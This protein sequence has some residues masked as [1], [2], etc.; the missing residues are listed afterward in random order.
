MAIAAGTRFG[1][2][3]VLEPLGAGGMGKVWRARDRRLNR[4][5][6]PKLLPAWFATDVDPPILRE[7]GKEKSLSLLGGDP[8]K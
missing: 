5:V 1:H 4:A 6:T 2:Y 7:A 8:L 3:H